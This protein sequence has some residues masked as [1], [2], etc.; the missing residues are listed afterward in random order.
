MDPFNA[1]KNALT[2]ILGAQSG[3]SL[4]VLTDDDRENIANFFVTAGIELGLWT[5]KI[6]L[7]TKKLRLTVPTLLKEVLF[8]S[9][10]KPDIIINILSGNSEEIPFRVELI[11]LEER[12]RC[13]IAHCPGITFDMLTEG[14]LSLTEEEH[15]EMQN[16]SFSLLNQL[17]NAEEIKLTNRNGT[18][19]TFS[20]ANRKFITDTVFD[21]T[22][23]KMMN[24]PTGEV[25]VAPVEKSMKGILVCDLAIGG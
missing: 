21:W 13:R 14:A 7:S 17:N 22:T 8:T 23:Y 20:V 12:L 10:I 15:K 16:R 9:A 2:L 18:N 6:I 24:L 3:E 1:A 11:H 19:L 4:L 5:R 25:M